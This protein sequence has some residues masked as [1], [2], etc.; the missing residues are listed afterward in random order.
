MFHTNNFL[1][2]F[3]LNTLGLCSLMHI[4]AKFTSVQARGYIKVF[5]TSKFSY[6]Y[7]R[8]EDKIHFILGHPQMQGWKNL[9]ALPQML[10][11]LKET[12]QFSQ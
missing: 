8:W 5:H 7:S 10:Q 11:G 4:R 2:T 12:V 6:L 1:N 9:G 3:I